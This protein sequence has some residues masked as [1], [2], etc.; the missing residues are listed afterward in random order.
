MRCRLRV[1]ASRARRA[2]DEAPG[3][4]AAR[5]ASRG[6]GD[7]RIAAR[8]LGLQA[9]AGT[10]AVQR[11]LGDEGDE[12]GAS[13]CSGAAITSASVDEGDQGSGAEQLSAGGVATRQFG[14]SDFADAP[15][16][17]DL[18]AQT[19]YSFSSSGSTFSAAFDA[20]R[21]WAK[22]SAK[23]AEGQAALLRHE[24][25]H[26]D[27]ATLMAQKATAAG[28]GGQAGMNTLV[29]P[30]SAQKNRY[31]TQTNH[32]T[33]GAQQGESNIDAGTVPYST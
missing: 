32:G 19:G 8:I 14:W 1:V 10:T 9:A 3:G 11:L 26:L 5:S 21:S 27:L 25:Y 15:E 16:T 30:A 13:R 33:D 7:E 20:S 17:E 4:K 31:D 12:A 28:R 24:Q 6:G 18:D 2:V 29:A 23:V 22:P